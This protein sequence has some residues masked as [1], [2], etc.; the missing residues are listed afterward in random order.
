MGQILHR[1]VKACGVFLLVRSLA[2]RWNSFK[3]SMSSPSSS[4]WST[5][6]SQTASES[7]WPLLC[8]PHMESICG[9]FY[10]QLFVEEQSTV[11]AAFLNHRHVGGGRPSCWLCLYVVSFGVPSTGGFPAVFASM[12]RTLK[13]V[14]SIK[15]LRLMVWANSLYERVISRVFSCRYDAERSSW[16]PPPA[17]TGWFVNTAMTT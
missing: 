17:P 14:F 2:G 15:L 16:A 5:W 3:A 11:K 9:G 7:E 1:H 12:R 13:C 8:L 4:P 6:R 10:S